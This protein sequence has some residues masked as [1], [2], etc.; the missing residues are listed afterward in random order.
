MALDSSVLELV[1]I[2]ISQS[3]VDGEFAV[4]R[5]SLLET[6]VV[7][8]ADPEPLT[9]DLA[10]TALVIGDMQNA[11]VKKG[12]MCDLW[13]H[14]ITP[15][16]RPIGPIRQLYN[17]ACKDNMKVIYTVHQYSPDLRESE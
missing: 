1:Y 14:D 6:P 9:I 10:R 7:I 2:R 8:E 16:Q 3:H 11:F 4:G 13:G 15:A 17:T 5:K 12:G